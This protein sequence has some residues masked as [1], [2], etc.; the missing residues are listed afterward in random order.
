MKDHAQYL[1]PRYDKKKAVLEASFHLQ[2]ASM[3][4]NEVL[5]GLLRA[6][7]QH[8]YLRFNLE[9]VDPARMPVAIREHHDIVD[10]I[11][12][13]DLQGAVEAI[14]LHVRKGRS[15]VV[16]GISKEKEPIELL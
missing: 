2:I 7:F 14:R 9:P 10:R 12:K 6:N 3:A 4:R 8:L 15:A 11:R 1:P 13:R 5:E 16:A